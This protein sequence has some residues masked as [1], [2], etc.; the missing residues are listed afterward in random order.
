M[1][2]ID[3]G[4]WICYSMKNL[5]SNNTKI[6]FLWFFLGSPPFSAIDY[7]SIV[8]IFVHI[9]IMMHSFIILS[10]RETWDKELIIIWFWKSYFKFYCIIELI[11]LLAAHLLRQVT[12]FHKFCYQTQRPLPF[13]MPLNIIMQQGTRTKLG[14][15]VID[16]F[17]LA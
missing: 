3:S 10:N 7:Y 15:I 9:I 14:S 13:I 6:S 5:L 16:N 17:C 8:I 4:F 11:I 1:W 2:I 12:V